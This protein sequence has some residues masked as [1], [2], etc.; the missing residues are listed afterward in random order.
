MMKT[1]LVLE[2]QGNGRIFLGTY[3]YRKLERKISSFVLRRKKKEEGAAHRSRVEVVYLGEDQ[4][5]YSSKYPFL[6]L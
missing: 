5:I 1:I 6:I 3:F 4:E 2:K